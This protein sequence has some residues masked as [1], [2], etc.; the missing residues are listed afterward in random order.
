M[1][2]TSR[3]TFIKAAAVLPLAA[4][5]HNST[6][7]RS[8]PQSPGGES[9]TRTLVKIG[10]IKLKAPSEFASSPF[11]IGCETLDRDLWKPSEVYP[12][13]K[14][15]PVKWARLQTGWE[16][17]EKI[18]GT[19]DWGWLD[20]S[21]DGLVNV[22]I[23]P[24][25]NVGYGNP[26]YSGGGVGFHPMNDTKALSGWKNFVRLLVERYRDRIT[27]YEIWNE[28]NLGGFWKPDAPDPAKY[29]A[30]VRETASLIREGHREAVIVGGVVSRLPQTYIRQLFEEGIAEHIDIFSFHPYTTVPE[31]YNARIQALQKL[32][33]QYKPTLQIWQGEN[34]YPSQPG[35]TGF[36][37]EGPWT[38][39]IQAKNMLRRLLTDCSLGLPMTLWFL[40]VDIH[41]YPKGS[42][43]VNYKGVLRAKPEI[44][45]KP[46]YHALQHLGS[47]V[48]GHIETRNAILQAMQASQP[49]TEADYRAFGN[50]EK[51]SLSNFQAAL[52]NTDMGPALAYWNTEKAAD[53]LED[54]AQIHLMLWDWETNGIHEPVLVD[55][56]TGAIYELG[57]SSR[58]ND[59]D[60]WRI[61]Q[62][63][64]VFQFIP[65]RDYPLLIMEK[66]NVV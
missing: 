55:P 51:E 3:R 14:S 35:S 50:G 42:G 61:S 24:F 39:N 27:H 60:K 13:I 2:T 26:H 1:S 62:E 52:F 12:W 7:N 53:T 31:H 25:F 43:K 48:H 36:S 45:P 56:F 63:V 22:G 65:L 16:R 41:D 40:I 32:A 4:Q 38:E 49:F 46:A 33:L 29:V 19:Y 23:N 6:E 18:K 8:N 57:S 58:M 66:G 54:K 9:A 20:E 30:L 17:V 59:D 64:Q 11:G 37:G 44:S 28:P 21:V 47:V 5:L 15:L 10:R 34:G